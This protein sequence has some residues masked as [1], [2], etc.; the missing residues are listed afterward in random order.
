M[1]T[2]AGKTWLMAVMLSYRLK[3]GGSAGFLLLVDRNNRRKYDG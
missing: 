2:G 1:A 3:H